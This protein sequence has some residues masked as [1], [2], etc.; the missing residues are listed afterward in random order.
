MTKRIYRETDSRSRS[1]F[2]AALASDQAGE[3][4]TA[5]IDLAHH[6]DPEWALDQLLSL[7]S[8][9]RAGVVKAALSGFGILSR[10]Q[11]LPVDRRIW[12]TLLAKSAD[13]AFSGIADDAMDDI[14]MFGMTGRPFHFRS[15]EPDGD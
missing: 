10:R 1:E 14:E 2:I 8:D 6:E 5:I 4:S 15:P 3:V 9:T 13:P 12:M 7:C 11:V